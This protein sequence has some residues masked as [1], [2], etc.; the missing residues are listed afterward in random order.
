MMVTVSIDDFL[1]KY[2]DLFKDKTSISVYDLNSIKFMVDRYQQYIYLDFCRDSLSS[3]YIDFFYSVK[4]NAMIKRCSSM[5]LD[6]DTIRN[7]ITVPDIV[8][9]C[10]ILYERKKKIIKL[11]KKGQN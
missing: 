2:F 3:I 6:E 9:Q 8:I 7:Y 10:M 5:N 11:I 1:Y 4:E